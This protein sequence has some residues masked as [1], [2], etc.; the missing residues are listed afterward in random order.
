MKYVSWWQKLTYRDTLE[1]NILRWFWIRNASNTR[2][3]RLNTMK[4]IQR[5]QPFCKKKVI[6]TLSLHKT[7]LTADTNLHFL[8]N[9]TCQYLFYMFNHSKNDVCNASLMAIKILVGLGESNCSKINS[10]NIIVNKFLFTVLKWASLFLIIHKN[11]DFR[12]L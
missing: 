6:A 12:C 9:I 8:C 3:K 11:K 7:E 5:L 4:L 1:K 10:W 2:S